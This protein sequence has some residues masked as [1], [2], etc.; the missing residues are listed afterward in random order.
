V[1]ECAQ[2]VGELRP[3]SVERGQPI[4]QNRNLSI[5]VVNSGD[6]RPFQPL[7]VAGGLFS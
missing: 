6:G 5:D 2:S 4:L 7:E 3:F 1:F